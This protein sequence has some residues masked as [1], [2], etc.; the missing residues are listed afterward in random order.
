MILSFGQPVISSVRV[1]YTDHVLYHYFS[2][3]RKIDRI[4]QEESRNERPM[5]DKMG[6]SQI[7]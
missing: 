7:K 2:G 6:I 3:S 1:L 4:N 5:G